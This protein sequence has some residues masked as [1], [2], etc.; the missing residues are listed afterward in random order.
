VFLQLL[1]HFQASNQL[2]DNLAADVQ[3]LQGSPS[4]PMICGHSPDCGN[5]GLGHVLRLISEFLSGCSYFSLSISL[6]QCWESTNFWQHFAPQFYGI[7]HDYRAM[8]TGVLA[9][10]MPSHRRT[11][12]FVLR[13]APVASHL[14]ISAVFQPPPCEFRWVPGLLSVPL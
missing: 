14:S 5:E 4:D 10:A 3:A 6:P 2:I 13:E 8:S 9:R 11:R 12:G 1:I 7:A